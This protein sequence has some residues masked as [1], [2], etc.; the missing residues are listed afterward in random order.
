MK[1]CVVFNDLSGY[2]NCS[3]MAAIPVLTVMGVRVHLCLRRCLPAK[4]AMTVTLWRI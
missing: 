2:G 1:N 3:L 4:P